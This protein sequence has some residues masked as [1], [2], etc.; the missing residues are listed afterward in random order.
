MTSAALSATGTLTTGGVPNVKLSGE[1]FPA[2]SFCRLDSQGRLVRSQSNSLVNCGSKGTLYLAL[3]ES[4]GANQY[5]PIA[6][7]GDIVTVSGL[8]QGTLYVISAATAGYV[9][10]IADLASTNILALAGFA[11]S[12]TQF[13]VLGYSTGVALP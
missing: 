6:Q 9:A 4:N 12:S 2:L 1:A 11:I 5:V 7:T 3:A 10:P 13:Q 8:T